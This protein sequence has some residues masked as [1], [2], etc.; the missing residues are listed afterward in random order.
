MK[1]ASA[2]LILDSTATWLP[3][4]TE[5]VA[6]AVAAGRL[7]ADEAPKLGLSR[8]P[9]SD[10]PAPDMAV[11]AARAALADAGADPAEIGFL[12]HGW[13]YHQGHDFWSPAH[14]IANETGAHSAFPVG[15]QQLSNAGAAALGLAVDRL[16]ADPGTGSA[17]VTTADRFALPGFDRW[18]ADYGVVYGDAGTAAVLRRHG[19]RPGGL[20][21]LSLAFRTAAEFEVMYRCGD[22]FAVAPLEHGGRID[23]RRPKKAYLENFGGNRNFQE[24]ACERVREVLLGALHDAEVEPDDSRIACIALPRLCDSVLEMMYLPVIEGQVKG[25]VLRLREGSGHLGAGD[26]LANLTHIRDAARLDS[27]E[28]AVLIGGGGGFTW[29]CAVVQAI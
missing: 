15:V 8:V 28:V 7:P 4:G 19:G 12:A 13:I 22:E 25:E 26:L 24:T 9:V 21:L 17:L 1:L 3:S 27:G 2:S 23:V 29:S 11:R 16:V 10:V 20:R 6:D 5:T 14:Y 18:S